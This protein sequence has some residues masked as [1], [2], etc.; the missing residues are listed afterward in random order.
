[1][2]R[3]SEHVLTR[4]Y[5]GAGRVT[6]RVDAGLPFRTVLARDIRNVRQIVG[7][8]YDEGLRAL[9]DYYRQ[10]FPSLMAK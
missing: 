7:P 3:F 4:N 8:K 9:L 6:A 10:K 2:M 5:G 1:M